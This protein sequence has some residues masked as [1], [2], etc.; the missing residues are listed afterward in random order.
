MFRKVKCVKVANGV[1]GVNECILDAQ[2]SRKA[3]MAFRD[4]CGVAGMCAGLVLI[5]D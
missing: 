2:K 4:F 5:S 3:T 1:D